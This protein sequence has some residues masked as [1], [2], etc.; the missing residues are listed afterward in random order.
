[1]L[2]YELS[3]QIPGM[4]ASVLDQPLEQSVDLAEIFDRAGFAGQVRWVIDGIDKLALPHERA[5]T[6]ID[7]LP[8]QVSE[9]VMTASSVDEI[10][11][12]VSQSFLKIEVKPLS[13][14]EIME[15]TKKYL[16]G[17]AK[18]LSGIQESHISN[19]VLLKNPETLMVFLEELLQ[20]GVHEKLGE[21][22]EGYLSARDV[23]EFY[24]RVLERLDK[25]FGFKRMQDVFS[26]IIMC[27]NGV[28]EEALVRHLRVAMSNGWL[29][30]RLSFRFCPLMEDIL[31]WTTSTC[32][33][34]LRSIMGYRL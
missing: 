6:W 7:S 18:A 15:I 23:E 16:E 30:I 4:D 5:A 31:P 20:F 12:V 9:I 21:F 24:V 26:W 13:A 1:M 8:S 34:R 11:S 32:R 19:S 2:I 3:C 17:F 28:P 22:V 29:S 10:S 27:E 14:G 25:D 33:P